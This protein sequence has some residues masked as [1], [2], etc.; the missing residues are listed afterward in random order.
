MLLDLTGTAVEVADP[1]RS[2]PSSSYRRDRLQENNEVPSGIVGRVIRR[3]PKL[4]SL[5]Y[6]RPETQPSYPRA[7]QCDRIKDPRTRV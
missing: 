2:P 6:H 5:I 7:K 4:H 1:A 3:K